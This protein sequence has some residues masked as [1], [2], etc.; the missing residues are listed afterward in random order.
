METVHFIDHLVYLVTTMI[1]FAVLGSRSSKIQDVLYIW[2][3]ENEH[4]EVYI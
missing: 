4:P 3:V 1:Y 2:Q